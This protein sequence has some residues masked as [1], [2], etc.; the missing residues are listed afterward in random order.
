[1]KILKALSMI[2]SVIAPVS[3]AYA[4]DTAALTWD[5]LELGENYSVVKSIPLTDQFTLKTKSALKLLDIISL[6]PVPVFTFEFQLTKCD[7]ATAK[8]KSEIVIV[9]D[10]YGVELSEGCNVTF[11]VEYGDYYSDTLLKAR[12]R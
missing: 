4:V 12:A 8:M 5:D 1:M 6:S 3:L 2:T 10:T 7:A 9:D 11:Y